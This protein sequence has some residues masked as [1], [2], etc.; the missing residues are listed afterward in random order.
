MEHI[1]KILGDLSVPSETVEKLF[2][3]NPD[4]DALASAKAAIEDSAKAKYGV[5]PKEV[6]DTEHQRATGAALAALAKEYATD[7]GVPIGTFK[8]D[9]NT[10]LTIGEQVNKYAGLKAAQTP[11]KE[12]TPPAQNTELLS[13]IEAL[14][15][16]KAALEAEVTAYKDKV[17]TYE[18]I[19]S[20]YAK[21]NSVNKVASALNEAHPNG[22][23]KPIGVVAE[24]VYSKIAAKYDIGEN[25][26]L[27]EKGTQTPIF[28]KGSTVPSTLGTVAKEIALVY[29]DAVK[30]GGG[31]SAP[32]PVQHQKQ[33]EVNGVVGFKDALRAAAELIKQSKQG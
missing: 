33:G 25:G 27:F 17:N 7:L 32:P 3:D 13:K 29:Y 24:D 28:P 1:K 19:V 20:E 4:A 14:N 18:P 21:G 6:L 31:K 5:V 12:D 10:F 16:A 22:F 30:S 8:K 9:A 15:A 2:T 26:M 23:N 11:K